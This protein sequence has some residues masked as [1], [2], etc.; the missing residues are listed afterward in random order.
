MLGIK[1]VLIF[2]KSLN[3]AGI[4]ACLKLEKDVTV[5]FI[6]PQ[7]QDAKQYLAELNSDVI[8]FD[9]GD[10]PNDL[11]LRLLRKQPDLLLIGVDPSSDEVLILKG[12]CSRVMSTGELSQLISNQTAPHVKDGF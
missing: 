9:L 8:L 11:D 1:R 5:E 12:Q 7:D 10:P 2:G 4:G 3:L 6:D